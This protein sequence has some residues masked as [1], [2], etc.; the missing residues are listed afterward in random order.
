M[1]NTLKTILL[2]LAVVLFAPAALAEDAKAAAPKAK[3]AAKPATKPDA[4]SD[5]AKKAA[6]AATK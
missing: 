4:K 1:K 6:P 5:E 2:A 3:P